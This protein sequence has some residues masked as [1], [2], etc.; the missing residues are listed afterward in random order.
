[1]YTTFALPVSMRTE[2]AA[3]SKITVEFG[4]KTPKLIFLG[5]V[6]ALPSR[7]S[8]SAATGK[9]KKLYIYS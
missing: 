8:G 4:C 6:F 3:F 5:S 7:D 9:G 2:L 1:M